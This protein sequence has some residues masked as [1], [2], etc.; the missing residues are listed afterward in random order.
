MTNYLKEKNSLRAYLERKGISY[1]KTKKTWR[2]LFHDDE[3]E[4][5]VLYDNVDGHVLWCPVCNESWNIFAICSKLTGIPDDK[6]HFGELLKSVRETLSIPHE[7]KKEKK[8]NEIKYNKFPED[9][10]EKEKINEQIKKLSEKKGHIKHAWKYKNKDSE[11]IALDVRFERDGERK[12]IITFWYSNK[13]EWTKPPVFFYGLNFVNKEK[14]YMIHEGAKC[15]DIGRENLSH[16]NHISWSGGSGKAHLADWSFLENSETYIMRDNDDA[17]LKAAEKI[18]KQVPHAKIIKPVTSG[19]GDDI[20]QFLEIMSPE[21]LTKYILNK[22]NHE[23][24]DIDEP[25]ESSESLPPS[26]PPPIGGNSFAGSSMPFKILGISDDGKAHFLTIHRRW[27]TY[28]L[29]ALSK[30][31]LQVLAPLS[32]W[33]AEYHQKNNQPEWDAAIDDLIQLSQDKDFDELI[34]RGRGAWRDDDKF[35]YHDGLNTYG[36]YDKKYIYVRAPRK[37][38]GIESEPAGNELLTEI[39]KTVFKISFETPADAVR[40]LGWAI[41]APFAGAL[42]MRPALLITGPTESGK[43]TVAREIVKKIADSKWLD[44]CSSTPAGVRGMIKRD[45]CAILFE[46][47]EADTPKKKQN[48]DELFGLMRTNVTEDSP[49]TAKG[50]KD[51]GYNSYKMQN[52]FGFIA[53]NP[54]VDSSADENRMFVVNMVIPANGAE[55]KG[56]DKKI[57]QLLT[58]ENCD[59]IRSLMW[60]RLPDVFELTDLLYDK[61]SIKLKK[62]RRRNHLDALLIA[63]YIII[64]MDTVKPDDKQIDDMLTKYYDYHEPE[65]QRDDA[66]EFVDRIL[67]EMVEVQVDYGREKITLRECMNKVYQ[68]HHAE[69]I[70]INKDGMNEFNY[71]PYRDTAARYGLRIVDSEYLGI[72]NNH[73]QIK[74]IHQCGMGYS[75]ILKRH[76]DFKQKDRKLDLFD[77]KTRS[78]TV[79]G[80]I[81]FQKSEEQKFDEEVGR[82]I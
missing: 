55:F 26:P 44:G 82:L 39:R 40:A 70:T 63:A 8:K 62:Y 43:S 30:S 37:N 68:F 48:R 60:T 2:C 5:A 18:K 20:E 57:K 1:N 67:D 69:D 27:V 54:I 3:T 33:R 11:T 29:S 28:E 58:D 7:E 59:K 13:L 77:G 76:K 80:N 9:E 35:S 72:C 79:I 66:E 41:L 25:A 15:V 46:E 32:Y 61:I 75:K 53:I 31:K 16:F 73:H 14:P 17:G 50:T 34:I 6:E 10:I 22:D 81:F 19:K 4:S 12:E 24:N 65:E 36:E 23:L 74:R 51:G 52:M 56:I 47:T 71:K 78:L 21:E 49:D 64:W 38:I 45:A 42:K